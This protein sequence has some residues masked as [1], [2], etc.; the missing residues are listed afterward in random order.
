MSA[1]LFWEYHN[2]QDLT[3]NL[4]ELQTSYESYLLFMK[5]STQ[6]SFFDEDKKF[7][8]VDRSDSN[9]RNLLNVEEQGSEHVI[10]QNAAPKTYNK[11]N[12]SSN[13]NLSHNKALFS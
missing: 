6:G 4:L 9:L 10:I 5:Q 8:Q 2:Y 3:A 12:I 11:Q 1:F 7:L 13:A